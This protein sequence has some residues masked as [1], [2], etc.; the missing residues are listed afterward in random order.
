VGID[1][2][3]LEA[4]KIFFAIRGKRVDGHDF[5]GADAV[6]QAPIAVVD[7]ASRVAELRPKGAT[8]QVADTTAALGLLAVA[9]REALR[10]SGCRVIAI[11]G[12]NGKTTTRHLVHT[13]LSATWRGT[14]SLH[15]FNNHIGVPLTLLAARPNDAFVVVEVGTN[16]PGEIDEL[17]RVVRPDAAV[18]TSIGREHLAF[19]DDV[20]AVAR[21]ESSVFRW[22]DPRGV[23]IIPA[24]CPGNEVIEAAVASLATVERVGL[25]PAT[26]V[27]PATCRGPTRV[28]LK[29][30]L[31]FDL[32]LSGRH[33]VHNALCAVAVARWLGMEDDCI[34]T[35]LAGVKPMPMRSEVCH[36]GSLD[37]GVTVLNDSYNAN[38]DSM[39]AAFETLEELA[40]FDP[41]R[42]CVVVL[43]DM[44]EMGD[45]AVVA[46]RELASCFAPFKSRP[47]VVVLVGPLMRS[48]AEVLPVGSSV[49]WQHLA[50]PDDVALKRV[51]ATIQAGDLVLVKGSRGMALERVVDAIASRFTPMALQPQYQRSTCR[52][53]APCGTEEKA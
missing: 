14:Q 9:Q 26:V 11:C 15:N 52:T 42:R 51:A 6:R 17:A 16:H 7:D 5:L 37:Q 50:S 49:Q 53:V 2:R 33:N 47:F 40:S 23:G 10:A 35:A 18:L 8:L 1:S 3:T 36:Y 24:T 12:S 27:E 34:A 25:D 31:R 21:E 22:V 43:G 20:E 45:A 41:R 44:F 29:D 30:G 13:V 4:G 48:L 38:P 46:H 28:V 32:P 39:C 19:F